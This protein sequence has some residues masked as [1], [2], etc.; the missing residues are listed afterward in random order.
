[1]T[2]WLKENPRVCRSQRES[3][4]VQVSEG[5]AVSWGTTC[6]GPGH[7]RVCGLT[8]GQDLDIIQHPISLT[9]GI[10]CLTI[11][12]TV[13]ASTN[14]VFSGRIKTDVGKFS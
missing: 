11:P 13:F 1:M 4:D 9:Q 3:R 2:I 14:F 12:I 10:S 5:S 6:Y 8:P 7:Q